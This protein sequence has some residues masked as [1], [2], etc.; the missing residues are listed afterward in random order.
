MDLIANAKSGFPI[1]ILSKKKID[2]SCFNWASHLTLIR[3]HFPGSLEPHEQTGMRK[4]IV[5]SILLPNPF[6]KWLY[7]LN[8]RPPVTNVNDIFHLTTL[9]LPFVLALSPFQLVPVPIYKTSPYSVQKKV[10]EQL[11]SVLFVQLSSDHQVGM[12]NHSQRQQQCTVT[13]SI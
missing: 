12:H 7:I 2:L 5:S 4:A 3:L 6:T 8:L 1:G 10:R 9:I 13:M 11:T